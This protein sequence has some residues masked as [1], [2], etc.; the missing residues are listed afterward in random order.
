MRKIGIMMVLLLAISTSTMANAELSKAIAKIYLT[1]GDSYHIPLEIGYVD[2]TQAQFHLNEIHGWYISMWVKYFGEPLKMINAS[3]VGY[4]DSEHGYLYKLEDVRDYS[5]YLYIR[6]A[7]GEESEGIK[8]IS[9]DTL[10]SRVKILAP[11]GKVVTLKL[12]D[13]YEITYPEHMTIEF[14]GFVQGFMT[15][16][17]FFEVRKF[18]V[19]GYLVITKVEKEKAKSVSKMQGKAQVVFVVGLN[20]ASSDV[21]LVSDGLDTAKRIYS[22]ANEWVPVIF[23]KPIDEWLLNY[24]RI[25]S[26]NVTILTDKEMKVKNE[27][28]TGIIVISVGGPAVN[29][30]TKE[31]NSKMPV[32]FEKE[33][34]KWI[35][36]SGERAWRGNYGVIELIPSYNNYQEM[37]DWVNRGNFKAFDII[38]A[39]LTREGTSIAYDYFKNSTLAVI[40]G[41]STDKSSDALVGEFLK[42]LLIGYGFPLDEEINSIALV[43]DGNGNVVD[44]VYG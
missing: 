15:S 8:V 35:L 32:K 41:N 16:K 33:N 21:Q 30:Y 13:S 6:L 40:S 42:G 34:G 2:V 20:A 43:I 27:N 3:E 36:K 12:G 22:S 44:V 25:T 17:V 38:I 37:T 11:N 4:Y 29:E 39:G 18:E 28:R 26:F 24:T 9:M 5:E 14:K 23:E 7:E 31:L 19:S 1:E 10:N